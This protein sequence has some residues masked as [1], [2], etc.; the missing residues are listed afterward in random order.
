MTF[1]FEV[2]QEKILFQ[3]LNALERLTSFNYYFSA[4]L[5]KQTLELL[6]ECWLRSGGTSQMLF[7][8]GLI[9][10][11]IDCSLKKLVEIDFCKDH[12]DETEVPDRLAVL[13]LISYKS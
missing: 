11:L 10:H 5:K 13:D 4:N 3:K 6:V 2:T 7:C 12:R 8:C 1:I 9:W